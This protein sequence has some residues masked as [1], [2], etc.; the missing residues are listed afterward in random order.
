MAKSNVER[1]RKA[2]AKRR[3]RGEREYRLWAPD[4]P[5]SRARLRELALTLCEEH[6]LTHSTPDEPDIDTE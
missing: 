1:V 6:R 3:A 4:T 5:E 2:E